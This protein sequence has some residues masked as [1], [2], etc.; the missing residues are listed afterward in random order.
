MDARIFGNL[1]HK[2]L[3]LAYDLQRVKKG[4][5][6]IDYE[7][8]RDI[9]SSINLIIDRAFALFKSEFP[10]SALFDCGFLAG[11]AALIY[12]PA[13]ILI[14]LLLTSLLVLRS[15]NIKEWL[16]TFIGIILPYF[17]VSVYM[18]WNHEVVGFW[19]KYINFF[20]DLQ[21]IITI[22]NILKVNVLAAYILILLIFILYDL[23]M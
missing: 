11:I 21:P 13:I 22:E 14:P 3:F 16:I 18:F 4:T 20:H 7:D 15:F 6:Q 10:V 1:L 5:N 12:F 17:F 8:F 23:R 19:K 9:K 2:V